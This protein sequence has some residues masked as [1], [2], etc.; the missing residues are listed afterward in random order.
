MPEAAGGRGRPWEAAGGRG[1]VREARE[2]AG[3]RRRAREGAG[4]RRRP[5]EAAGGRRRLLVRTSML[6][7]PRTKSYGLGVRYVTAGAG[8][9]A[10]SFKL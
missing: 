7:H 6:S 1:R 10:L 2:G 3:G 4:G 8:A 5:P 9:A